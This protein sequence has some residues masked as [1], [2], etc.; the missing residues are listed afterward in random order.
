MQPGVD[1]CHLASTQTYGNHA[2]RATQDIVSITCDAATTCS[3][4]HHDQAMLFLEE[5][6]TMR[7]WSTATDPVRP[8]PH[9]TLDRARSCAWFP[10]EPRAA[11]TLRL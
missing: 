1:R 5:K 9:F 4:V 8:A 11:H 2:V 3:P 7:W 10:A 6:T